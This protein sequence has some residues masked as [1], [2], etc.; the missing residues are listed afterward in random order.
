MPRILFTLLL[1]ILVINVQA[2]D[3][4]MTVYR[5][6]L[7]SD[8]ELK[9]AEAGHRANLLGKDKARALLLP[10]ADLSGSTA[11]SKRDIESSGST[12]FDNTGYTLSIAQPI[13]RYDALVQNKQADISIQQSQTALSATQQQIILKAAERYF[14]LLSSQ[15]DLEFAQ[16]EKTA[17]AKQLE[18]AKK[19]FDVGLIAIT[20]VHE[21]QAAYDLATAA[22][23]TAVNQLASSIEALTEITG[24]THSSLAKLGQGLPLHRPDPDNMENWTDIALQQNLQLKA[25]EL[26]SQIAKEDIRLQRAGHYPSLDIVASHDFSDNTR[27]GATALGES[28]TD[29]IALQLN[30]PLYKGG[31]TTA[32]VKE[33]AHLYTQALHNLDQERRSVLRQ[34]RDAF[35]GVIN[36]IGQVLALKQATVSNRSALETTQAGFEV[37]TRT[38]V[39][40][41]LAQRGLFGAKRDHDQSRHQYI[42]NILR[43]KLAAGTLSP[44]DLEYFNKWLEQ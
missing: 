3:D 2:S 17:I 40:V 19:R 33:S 11:R 10:N 44:E 7:D 34:T 30:V 12:T 22:E 36:G 26:T 29:S 37:G 38:I 35:R 32:Q 21:A 27:I 20:D 8:P 25:L 14:D 39:D 23:I 9:A 18:Q 15:A 31:L 6:V 42:L 13:F 4:L 16:S 41:L 24:S 1:S 28:T 5:Q 43:L